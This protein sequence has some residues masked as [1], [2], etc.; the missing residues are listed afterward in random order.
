MS[1][2]SLN[3]SIRSPTSCWRGGTGNTR[4][5]ILKAS[6][7][8]NFMENNYGRSSRKLC[9][10]ALQEELK[11]LVGQAPVGRR[12]E[13]SLQT[14]KLC[15]CLHDLMIMMVI[16]P[17]WFC[18][19]QKRVFQWTTRGH[20]WEDLSHFILYYL[21][22]YPSHFLACVYWHSPLLPPPRLG[23]PKINSTYHCFWKEHVNRILPCSRIVN[24]QARMLFFGLLLLMCIIPVRI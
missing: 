11:G 1:S 19:F 10:G 3:S 6:A 7:L 20:T 22:F 8:A 9:L 2:S 4:R 21:D 5:R 14:F 17:V 18:C 15:V 23:K 24:S 12:C 13:K 16:I